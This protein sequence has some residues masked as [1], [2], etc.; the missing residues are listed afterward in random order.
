MKEK[1][2]VRLRDEVAKIYL[3]KFLASLGDDLLAASYW[4]H[5]HFISS[6]RIQDKRSY[7]ETHEESRSQ[8]K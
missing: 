1:E 2:G 3:G 4:I 6:F 5:P 7:V 8:I